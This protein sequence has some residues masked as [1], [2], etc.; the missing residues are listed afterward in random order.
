MLMKN[1][2]LSWSVDQ[3]FSPAR[4]LHDPLNGEGSLWPLHHQEHAV[5]ATHQGGQGLSVPLH[6]RVQHAGSPDQ[7]EEV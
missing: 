6:G 7:A 4:D 3:F 5:H 1:Y 2:I